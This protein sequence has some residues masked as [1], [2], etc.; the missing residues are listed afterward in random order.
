MSESPKIAEVPDVVK[1]CPLCAAPF[2]E[3]LSGNK[4]HTCPEDEGGCG[5]TFLVK[6]Y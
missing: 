4:K 2:Q 1:A 6:K 5:G 3:A